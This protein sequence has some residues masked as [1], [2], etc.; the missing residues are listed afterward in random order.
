MAAGD[1]AGADR[2]LTDRRLVNLSSIDSAMSDPTALHRALLAFLRS[3]HEAAQAFANEAIA[4]YRAQSWTPRNR[5][6]VLLGM[7]RAEA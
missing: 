5:P 3:E 6:Y 7:A 2:V 4:F 1:Y